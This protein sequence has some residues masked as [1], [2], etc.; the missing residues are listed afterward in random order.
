[1]F[2]E[3]TAAAGRSFPAM[4]VVLAAVAVILGLLVAL[5]ALKRHQNGSA[6]SLGA[7]AGQVSAAYA[8]NL[9]LAGIEMS[10]STSF[11]GGKETYLDGKVSNSGSAT[12]TGATA[13]VT[14]AS[15][16][17]TPQ[18]ETVPVNLIRMRQPYVDTAPISAAP[19]AP[20]A[21]AE[22]RLIFDDVKPEWNQQVPEIRV[23]GVTTR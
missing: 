13:Q 18:V 8:P 22:F 4:P 14:F 9:H 2:S 12:V 5:G 15:D 20:G 17:G 6:A 1:M 7:G 3:P 16:G 19:I 21:T 11:S 10:E 23:T